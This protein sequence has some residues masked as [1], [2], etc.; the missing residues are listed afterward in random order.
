M[1]NLDSIKE[2][3]MNEFMDQ[4]KR[5]IR[6]LKRMIDDFDDGRSK[7]FFCRAACLHDLT[8]LESAL[9]EAT[10]KIRTDN[11]KR[12]DRKV[13]AKVLKEILGTCAL[14]VRAGGVP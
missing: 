5:R 13:K 2:H 9:N 8:G 1:S 6:F 10:R 14:R 4:Q 7:S 3:G 11:I 12:G